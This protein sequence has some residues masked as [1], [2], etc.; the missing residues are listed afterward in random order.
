M[1]GPLEAYHDHY[2]EYRPI[3]GGGPANN[4][5]SHWGELVHAGHCQVNCDQGKHVP[6]VEELAPPAT[7]R[8]ALGALTN[9]ARTLHLCMCWLRDALCAMRHP[10]GYRLH[11]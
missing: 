11:H 5:T 1:P 4:P 10:K 2:A 9:L 8:R 6:P 3:Q 7:G